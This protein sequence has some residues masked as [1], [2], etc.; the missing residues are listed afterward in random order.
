MEP[1]LLNTPFWLKFANKIVSTEKY[2]L[3]QF[4]QQLYATLMIKTIRAFSKIGRINVGKMY[5]SDLN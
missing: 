1:H 2:S 5:S 3:L 4:A